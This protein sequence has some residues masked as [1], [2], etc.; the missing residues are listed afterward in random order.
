MTEAAAESVLSSDVKSQVGVRRDAE[1]AKQAAQQRIETAKQV[2]EAVSQYHDAADRIDS[3]QLQTR[4]ATQDRASALQVMRQCGLT[5]AE[6]SDLTGM[7]SSRVQVLLRG[8]V[9]DVHE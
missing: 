7:S 6:I 1:R 3:A 4:Q 2:A 5:V 9:P 8:G